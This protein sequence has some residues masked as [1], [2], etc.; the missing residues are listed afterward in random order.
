M[1]PFLKNL[2]L[3][4]K[5]CKHLEISEKE[6]LEIATTN[7]IDL[8]TEYVNPRSPK[9][10][11]FNQ[12]VMFNPRMQFCVFM[13]IV[14][15]DSTYARNA[16]FVKPFLKYT[17]LNINSAEGIDSAI[18]LFK[19]DMSKAKLTESQIKY[20]I[21]NFKNL[22]F[23]VKAKTAKKS[24]SSEEESEAEEEKQSDS[25]IVRPKSWEDLGIGDFNKDTISL[26][27]KIFESYYGIDFTKP[28]KEFLNY[29]DE[30]EEFAHFYYISMCKKIAKEISG[31]DSK[32]GRDNVFEYVSENDYGKHVSESSDP[33]K[34][35]VFVTKF[36][37]VSTETKRWK[38]GY[39]TL[40]TNSLMRNCLKPEQGNFLL[41]FDLSQAE[42]RVCGWLAKEESLLQAYRDGLDLHAYNASKMFKKDMEDVTKT[43]RS[44]AKAL[45]FGIL[46]GKSTQSMYSDGS[47]NSVEEAENNLS[48]FYEAYPNIKALIDK[49]HRDLLEYKGVKTI[50]GDIIPLEFN[51]SSSYDLAKAERQSVNYLIQHAS[52]CVAGESI[53]LMHKAL[54]D[55]G[56]YNKPH[57]FTHDASEFE[58]RIAD[59]K[60]VLSIFKQEYLKIYS[61][62]SENTPMDIDSEIGISV[63][64]LLHFSVDGDILNI[65]GEC[66]VVDNFM[67]NFSEKLHI[68]PENIE[69]KKVLLPIKDLYIKSSYHGKHE[70]LYKKGSVKLVD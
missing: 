17:K 45:T 38:S 64:E 43:E 29:C 10:R 67:N 9:I 2:C 46:Y 33:D 63:G 58:F 19:E 56:I 36:N 57:S 51:D 3:N 18:E 65:E 53:Y 11:E 12:L 69:E 34:K 50:F 54:N 61:V 62:L 27:F 40:G 37:P 15:F 6:K 31:Y 16:R 47:F 59:M 4:E 52:T 28:E 60:K 41:H 8:L 32:L 14:K 39:H 5:I 7:S 21:D 48:L 22:T 44:A 55:L 23:C 30:Y 66:Y 35:Y 13:E 20:A 70:R 1:L 49:Q 42:V 26:F 68:I 25:S 24:N